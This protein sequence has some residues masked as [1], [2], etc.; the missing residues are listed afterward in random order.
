[1]AK[2][3]TQERLPPQAVDVEQAILGSLLLDN[4]SISR[5]LEIIST[6]NFY[7]ESH[8]KIFNAILSLYEHG[9]PSDIVTV[10]E[11][12]ER[13]GHLEE[14][15]GRGYIVTLTESVATSA[16]IEDHCR[17]ILEKSTLSNLITVSTG[18]ISE[19]YD[20]TERVDE[21]LDKAEH[22][23]FSIRESRLK[24]SFIRLSEILPHTFEAID[25]YAGREGGITGV[26]TGFK[27]IDA[28]TAGLQ[29][30]DLVVIA[31]RPSMGKTAFSLALAE[32]VAMGPGPVAFFSLEMSKEQL[33]QRLLCGRAKVSSHRL[34]RG[35][36]KDVELT[37]LTLAAGPL[38]EAPIFIDDSPAISVLEMKAKARRLKSSHGL[39]MVVI[40]YLQLMHAPKTAENRQQEIAYISRSLKALAKELNVPVVALSQLSR[41]VELRGG[42]RRPQLS[43]LRE[44]GAIEQDADV[45]MF[46]YRPAFYGK[47]VDDEGNSL[48]NI[49]EII[50]GKQRNGPTGTVKLTFIRDFA[51]FG[52]LDRQHVAA[53]PSDDNETPF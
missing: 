18:I 20:P 24:Q 40:D 47:T 30:S 27:D 36:L 9:E 38:N 48:E 8:R 4:E 45:V 15:G 50:I 53:L 7:R 32:N 37:N 22:R 52:E 33:A 17:I 1:V 51:S 6:E 5:A 11:K 34:R 42:D 10:S 44:S 28:L 21:L 39:S 43:D 19:C 25:D 2:Q 31:S 29:K 35:R 49:A 46:I 3:T 16:N 13:N 14:I 26:S 12:L 23:I 41:Q